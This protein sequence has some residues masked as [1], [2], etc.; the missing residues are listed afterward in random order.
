MKAAGRNYFVDMGFAFFEVV[1]EKQA[2]TLDQIEVGE[3]V[4]GKLRFALE[5]PD[6]DAVVNRLVE[7]GAKM[8][9]SPKEVPWG[10]R[11]ARL[12]DPEGIHLTFF[13]RNK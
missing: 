4:S 1:D 13:E 6:L 11:I 2:D 3:R 7:Y 8:I 10:D 12:I 9:Q 5:V